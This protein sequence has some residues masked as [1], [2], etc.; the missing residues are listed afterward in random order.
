VPNGGQAPGRIEETYVPVVA[1]DRPA[2]PD[3]DVE[4]ARIRVRG[5]EMEI[6]RPRSRDKDEGSD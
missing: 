5:A 3:E 4:L 6:R 1:F 2:D